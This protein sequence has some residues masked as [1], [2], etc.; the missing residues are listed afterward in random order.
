MTFICPS[1]IG[2]FEW[3]CFDIWVKECWR[4]LVGIWENIMQ[5]YIDDIVV[6]SAKFDSHLADL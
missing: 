4:H 5:V 2:L 3:V 6:K 1:F